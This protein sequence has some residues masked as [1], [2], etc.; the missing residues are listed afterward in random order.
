MRTFLYK[1]NPYRC[2]RTYRVDT[3]VLFKLFDKFDQI[4]VITYLKSGLRATNIV[5][6][7]AQNVRMRRYC[8]QQIVY[9]INVIALKVFSSVFFFLYI[10]VFFDCAY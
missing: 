10:S 7:I 3:V 2:V 8:R 9:F 5:L 6:T 1:T 4:L